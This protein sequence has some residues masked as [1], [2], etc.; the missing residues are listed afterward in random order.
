MTVY[1][2]GIHRTHNTA[3]DCLM[4]LLEGFF[5]LEIEYHRK[6][7]CDAPGTQVATALH[8]SY[9]LQCGDGPLLK[10]IGTVTAQ[11]IERMIE[12]LALAGDLRDVFAARDSL[13]S[14]FGLWP[15]GIRPSLSGRKPP[16]AGLTSARSGASHC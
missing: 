15:E 6:M 14:L 10:R 16:A 8:T 11:D 1:W 7:R 9:A 2:P 3:G 5:A 13:I 4:P 12:R